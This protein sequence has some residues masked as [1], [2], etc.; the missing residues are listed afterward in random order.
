MQNVRQ[1]KTGPEVERHTLHKQDEDSEKE[2]RAIN[3]P[4]HQTGLPLNQL[5]YQ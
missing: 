1:A 4:S 2:S 5:H 3:T